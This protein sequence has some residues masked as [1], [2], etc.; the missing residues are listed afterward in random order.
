MVWRVNELFVSGSV[1]SEKR[2]DEGRKYEEE[3]HRLEGRCVEIKISIVWL[4]KRV[5]A[6]RVGQEI[7]SLIEILDWKSMHASY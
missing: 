4:Q 1:G 6:K 3:G 2:R 5:E 7:S